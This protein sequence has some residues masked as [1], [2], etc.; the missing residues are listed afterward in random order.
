VQGPQTRIYS[1]RTRLKTGHYLKEVT[2]YRELLSYWKNA[3][4]D[5]HPLKEAN[6]EYKKLSASL[7]PSH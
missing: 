7:L 3:D 4:P 2:Q 6:A 1:H 5:L